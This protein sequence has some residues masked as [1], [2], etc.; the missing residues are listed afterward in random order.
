MKPFGRK[1]DHYQGRI[2]DR[3]HRMAKRNEPPL[4]EL[5]GCFLRKMRE[6]KILL[7]RPFLRK[8][9]GKQIHL[10]IGVENKYKYIWLMPAYKD[11]NKKRVEEG[12]RK[13]EI[14]EP[15][16]AYYYHGAYRLTKAGYITIPKKV[17][18]IAGFEGGDV[19]IVGM[20]SSIEVWNRI[21]W[22][23]VMERQKRGHQELQES[24]K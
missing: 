13:P 16:V 12:F 2:F 6:G 18:E 24:H 3:R 15:G 8:L 7:P 17:R 14:L 19:I 1:E 22:E 9:P 11:I 4:P 23:T 20:F 5:I 21:D 10:I